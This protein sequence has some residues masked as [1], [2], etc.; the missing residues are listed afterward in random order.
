MTWK[1]EVEE[2]HSVSENVGVEE[3]KYRRN[4]EYFDYKSCSP[5]FE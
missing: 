5:H 1:A 4:M 2:V 3:G